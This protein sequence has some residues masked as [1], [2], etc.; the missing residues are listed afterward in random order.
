MLDVN[1]SSCPYLDFKFHGTEPG[2]HMIRDPIG[3]R[4]ASRDSDMQGTIFRT[5]IES[6]EHDMTA[7]GAPND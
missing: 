3:D 7:T 1:V 4:S 2:F 5:K 6:N